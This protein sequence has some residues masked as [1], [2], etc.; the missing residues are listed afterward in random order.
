[1]DKSAFIT[2]LSVRLDK[3]FTEEQRSFISNFN[4]SM[5]SFSLPGTGKT[6]AAVA[7]LITAEVFDKIPGDQIYALSFTRNSTSELDIRHEIACQTLRMKQKVQ[8]RTLHALCTDIVREHCRKIGISKLT[9]KDATPRGMAIEMVESMFRSNNWQVK[10][11]QAGRVVDAIANCNS[12]FLFDRDNVESRYIFKKS[13]LSFDDFCYLRYQFYETNKSLGNIP[14]GDIPMYALEILSKYPEVSED[15]K[16]RCKIMLIDEFQDMSLLQLQIVHY[17]A[18]KVIAI[19]DI[20]QQ[21]YAFNGACH[22]IVERYREFYPDHIERNL[23]QSFRCANAIADYTKK[24]IVFNNTGGEKIQGVD[25]DGIVEV[26]KDGSLDGIAKR[27]AED[28]NRANYFEKQI[29]FLYRNNYSSLPIAEALFNYKVPFYVK[30]YTPM[31]QRMIARD[32]VA[33]IGLLSRPEDPNGLGILSK[34]IPEFSQYKEAQRNPLYNIMTETGQSF[35]EINWKYEGQTAI[36]DVFE[37]FWEVQ[38][39]LRSRAPVMPLFHS[40]YEILYQNSIQYYEDKLDVAPST[41][42]SYLE[43]CCGRRNFQAFIMNENEKANWI[44]ENERKRKGVRCMTFHG[45]KGLEADVVHIYDAEHGV[46]PARNKLRDM[47]SR[48]CDM[49]VARELRN[50]RSLAYVACTRAKTELYIHYSSLYSNIFAGENPYQKWDTI[51]SIGE[52]THN[53][54][55]AFSSFV[56]GVW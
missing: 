17:L 31:H 11:Y 44:K 45:A 30:G 38:E 47:A 9:I 32:L 37:T 36:D 54:H 51:Y 21:I 24:I 2:L 22:E 43:T 5:L 19:G 52:D 14:V 15:F 18:D 53:D 6:T 27:I 33:T 12:S 42:M 25:K 16:S 48:G 50:E 41:I 35:M 3:T 23:T 28:Y 4:R 8:F 39:G 55:L 49:D 13:G 10:P 56:E 29:M 20:N 34:Y 26:S 7:G 40:L 46:V 1:M